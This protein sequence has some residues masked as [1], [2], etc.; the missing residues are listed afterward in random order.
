MSRRI[1]FGIS[2]S[3]CLAI[4]L[5]LGFAQST[6]SITGQWT[7]SGPIVEERVQLSIRR[8]NPRSE[9]NSSSLLP[10]SQFSGLTRDQLGSQ[11]GS[12]ARFDIVR[13]AGTFRLEGFLQNGSGGGNFTFMPNAGYANDMRS[14]GYSDLSDENIFR[15]AIHDVSL[16]FVNEMAA[17]GYKELKTDKL[18]TMRIHGVTPN[19]IREIEALGFGRPE[20]DQ[21]VRMKIHGITPDFIRKVR[22]RGFSN[23]SIDQMVRLK[24]HGILN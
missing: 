17:M 21:L 12:V 4:S 15:L 18:I 3:L 6:S 23:A 13:D 1:Y 14:R 16:Q 22:A 7:I 9:M 5:A 19:F 24:V 11:T 10:L 8:Y 2:V 20:I